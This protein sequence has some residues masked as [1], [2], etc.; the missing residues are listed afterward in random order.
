MSKGTTAA[1]SIVGNLGRDPEVIF[2]DTGTPRCKLAVA[3][4]TGFGD[5]EATTWYEVVV[6]GK[7]SEFI[8][9]YGKKGSKVCV[10]G[11]PSLR[12]YTKKDGTTGAS[13]DVRAHTVDLLDRKSEGAAQATP[14]SKSTRGPG[15]EDS[16]SSL[17][18]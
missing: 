12:T 7:A 3:V 8:G 9:Q 16:D 1:I 15:P 17:P 2:G 5:H 13:L 14:T 18:F 10:I 4:T 11:E 6:F